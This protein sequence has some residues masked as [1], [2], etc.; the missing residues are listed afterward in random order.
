DG[1]VSQMTLLPNATTD[2]TTAAPTLLGPADGA[3]FPF[4]STTVANVTLAWSTVTDPSGV[5]AYELQVNPNPNFTLNSDNANGSLDRGSL[6][7][8]QYTINSPG[9]L[10]AP[11]VYYWR[12]RTLD[13]V[14]NFSPWSAARSFTA[15]TPPP[16]LMSALTLAPSGVTGG[17][18]AQGSIVLT[19]PAP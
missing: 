8:T 15:G 13:G 9:T 17:S 16:T 2:T 10:N 19:T 5:R 18:T 12:V 14:N 1:F 4:S 3:T 7:T 11:G 6:T